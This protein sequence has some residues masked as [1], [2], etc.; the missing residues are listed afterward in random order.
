MNLL[1]EILASNLTLFG[2]DEGSNSKIISKGKSRDHED[3]R[4]ES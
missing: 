4:K 3:S 1:M 2:D